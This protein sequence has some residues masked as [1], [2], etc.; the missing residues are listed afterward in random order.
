MSIL[1]VFMSPSSKCN[2]GTA[3]LKIQGVFASCFLIGDYMHVI[4]P[5]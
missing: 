1:T 3:S 2:N 4:F 5:I